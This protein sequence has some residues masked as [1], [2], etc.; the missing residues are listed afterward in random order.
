MS[1][2][3]LSVAIDTRGVATVNLNRP[4][5]MNAFD[6]A[7]IER[8]TESFEQLSSDPDV[9]VVVI[10][11]VGK[12]FCAGADIAWMQRAAMR[13]V[14]ENLADARRF[15]D[16]MATVAGCAKPVIARVQGAAYGGGVGIVCAADIAIAA[17]PSCFSVREAKFGILPAVIGP[18][19]VNAVGLREAR[20]LALTC[21]VVDA[22]QALRIGLIHEAVEHSQ[23]DSCVERHVDDLL[24]AGPQAQRHIKQ[25]FGQLSVGPVTA[26]LRELT[27]QTI[28]RVR[29]TEEARIGF[30]SF[31]EKTAPPWAVGSR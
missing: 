29:T 26:E 10:G 30:E 11:A 1:E 18:Y 21:A 31:I 27:A 17:N 3:N 7:L 5:V 2:S 19:L 6:E 8:I 23:L 4:Q 12:T 16:M 13:G 22:D 20:R 14:D 9:R 15:A 25:L 24:R 28:S